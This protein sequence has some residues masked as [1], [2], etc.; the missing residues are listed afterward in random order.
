VEAELKGCTFRPELTAT[1]AAAAAATGGSSVWERLRKSQ[2]EHRDR[3]DAFA[4]AQVEAELKECTFRPSTGRA[5]AKPSSA[6]GAGGDAAGLALAVYERLAVAKDTE[7][8]ER[9]KEQRETDGCTFAPVT[10]RAPKGSARR[11]GALAVPWRTGGVRSVITSQAPPAAFLALAPT[12]ARRQHGRRARPRRVHSYPA[13]A[14]VCQL[15]CQLAYPVF[16]HTHC[17]P[18]PLLQG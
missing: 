18:A 2:Q 17:A 6:A 15:V 4:L 13:H 3:G 1:A 11:C 14:F 5:P 7:A 12:H 16:A 8:L 9:R 10:S